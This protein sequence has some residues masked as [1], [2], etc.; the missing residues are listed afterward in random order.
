[1]SYQSRMLTRQ[2]AKL[3]R[4]R[5]RLL[6]PEV[7]PDLI[8]PFLA[9]PMLRGF[10]AGSVSNLGNWR[11]IS[12]MNNILLFNGDPVYA[13]IPADLPGYW[14][15]DGVGDYHHITDAA[16]GNNFD[17]IGTE[18]YVFPATRGLTFGGW[19]YPAAD[20]TGH[21]IGKANDTNGPYMLLY[22]A[23]GTA[24]FRIRDAGD[25]NNFD[26]S[27]AMVTDTWQFIVGRYDPGTEIKIW[28]GAVTNT[29]VAGIPASILDGAD[30][31]SIGAE[32][33]GGLPFTGG[34]AYCFVCAA[35]LNDATISNIFQQT[36][37]AF[38]V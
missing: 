2:I 17:I 4:D 5:D 22:V 23:G 6:Q 1:M 25:A 30:N 11:D 7:S 35:Q 19:F 26:V 32:G 29:N 13:Q 3:Q 31:F 20:V 28:N 36:R 38:G 37:G 33:A 14:Y 34:A 18:A 21:M 15:Y 24:L 27:V 12:G 10:W 9:L 16:S 8:S